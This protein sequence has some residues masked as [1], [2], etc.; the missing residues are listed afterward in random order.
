TGNA[1]MLQEA[2]RLR[3]Q[4]EKDALEMDLKRQQLADM[5]SK[6]NQVIS[7]QFEDENGNPYIRTLEAVGVDPETGENIYKEVGRAKKDQTAAAQVTAGAGGP[8]TDGGK[9][10]T[11]LAFENQLIAADQTFDGIDKIKEIIME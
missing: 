7:A 8:K 5:R 3:A 10:Q 9:N 4:Q 11:T 1:A 2:A 6:P